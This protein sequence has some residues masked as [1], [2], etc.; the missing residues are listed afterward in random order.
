MLLLSEGTCPGTTTRGMLNSRPSRPAP[1]VELPLASHVCACNS[2]LFAHTEGDSSN[3]GGCCAPGRNNTVRVA[4]NRRVMM[5]RGKSFGSRPNGISISTAMKC[6]DQYGKRMMNV[7]I[8][9]LCAVRHAAQIPGQMSTLKNIS[10]S[11]TICAN[12]NGNGTAVTLFASMK[13]EWPIVRSWKARVKIGGST[14]TMRLRDCS[15][16]KRCIH[17]ST[18]FCF[19]VASSTV[20]KY[21]KLVG[22]MSSRSRCMK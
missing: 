9:A 19:A 14:S 16:T 7:N 20:S 8:A 6:I 5:S 3:F 11:H 10:M 22:S 17:W 2:S 12:A 13:W 1:S 18:T 4:L 15:T 21:I